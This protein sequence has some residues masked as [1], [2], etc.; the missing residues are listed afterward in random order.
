[1]GEVVGMDTYV[2]GREGRRVVLL[3]PHCRYIVY[4]RSATHTKLIHM[5][6]LLPSQLHQALD[7]YLDMAQLRIR[8]RK[9]LPHKTVRGEE[10]N[11]KLD[12]E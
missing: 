5:S 6:T 12:S 1:M 11:M 9:G 3:K 10:D 8:L 4:V 2:S 7:D